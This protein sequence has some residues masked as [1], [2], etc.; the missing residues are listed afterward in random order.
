MIRKSYRWVLPLLILAAVVFVGCAEN[1]KENGDNNKPPGQQQP[2]LTAAQLVETRCTQCH[3]LD[4]LNSKPRNEQEWCEQ[5]ER[6]LDKSPD[7]LTEEEYQLV[8]SYLQE[9][10]NKQ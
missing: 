7:L 4:R 6:M 9:Q 1:N 5:A 8:V 10:E 2:E 3:T